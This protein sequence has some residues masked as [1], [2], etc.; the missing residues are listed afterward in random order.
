MRTLHLACMV[1]VLFAAAA[2]PIPAAEAQAVTHPGLSNAIKATLKTLPHVRGD[3]ID[4]RTFEQKVVV[5]TFF[6][7]W[8][9]PCRQEF[10][11]LQDI[12]NAYHASGVEIIAVNLFENF[13]NLSNDAQLTTYLH[14]TQPPFSVVKGND[15]ISRNFGAITRIPTLFV[16]DKQGQLALHFFNKPD[17]SQPTID[18]A[19]LRQVITALL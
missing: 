15:T 16:F 18:L 14:L 4:D 7:S 10:A 11:H 1:L 13:D 2:K 19:T 6:A 12:Y 17:G 8:C 9:V 3:R 5:V